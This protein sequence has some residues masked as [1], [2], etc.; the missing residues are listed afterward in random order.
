M[1]A[2]LAMKRRPRVRQT[3]FGADKDQTIFLFGEDWQIRWSVLRWNP[4]LQQAERVA[5]MEAGRR[6]ASY[7]VV[8]ESIFVV[9]GGRLDSHRRVNE[10]LVREGRWRER[11]PLAVGRSWRHAA[12]VVKDPTAA[13]TVV[14]GP[15]TCPV[16]FT[17]MIFAAAAPSRIGLGSVPPRVRQTFFGADKDQTIFLFGEDWQ[18]RWSVLRWNPHLQQAERVAD[19]EAGRRSASYSV[20]G[21]SIFVVGGGRLDSHRRVNEF[22]VREGRW[23]ERAPLAVGRSWRHAA[24]VVK[25][26]TAATTVVDGPLTCPV[27]FTAMIFA[28]AAPSRIGL[29]SVP[30]TKI[31]AMASRMRHVR[32]RQRESLALSDSN[33]GKSVASIFRHRSSSMRGDELPLLL[34]DNKVFLIDDT[35]KAEL[36][37]AFFAKHLN[38][39]SE[40]VSFVRSL[41]DRTLSKIDVSSDLIKKHISRLKH[42][43]CSGTGGIPNSTVKQA[44]DLPILL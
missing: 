34:N 12:A 4:H 16:F 38:T 15:L 26:P 42:S 1:P 19:M 32:D 37:S 30:I 39:E 9:G 18:I 25:D 28:A 23:R 14:D 7:S 22:L 36:F 17:A 24:A 21:E 13:T 20:V 43:R 35:E 2:K 41:S 3:F 40:P 5:D 29:G 27:F 31:M 44:S 11:A 33:P 6:S 8:G 10:F